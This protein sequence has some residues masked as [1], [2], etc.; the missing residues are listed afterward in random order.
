MY[1]SGL[2]SVSHWPRCLCMSGQLY[3]SSHRSE[4]EMYRISRKEIPLSFP[5]TGCCT[6]VWRLTCTEGPAKYLPAVFHRQQEKERHS[7]IR[8]AFADASRY[9]AYLEKRAFPAFLDVLFYFQQLWYSVTKRNG[10]TVS[11]F[12]LHPHPNKTSDFRSVPKAVRAPW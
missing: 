12:L 6:T 1:F 2:E 7:K 4:G 10:F 3:S 5:I 8:I 9:V 11:L